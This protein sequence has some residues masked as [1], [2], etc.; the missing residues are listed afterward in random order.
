MTYPMQPNILLT[1][2]HSFMREALYLLLLTLLSVATTAPAQESGQLP[3]KKIRA[4]RVGSLHFGRIVA[5]GIDEQ[6]AFL[7][8][9]HR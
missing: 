4:F 6:R 7:C 3:P 5:Q 1:R 8:Q 2:E 9:L